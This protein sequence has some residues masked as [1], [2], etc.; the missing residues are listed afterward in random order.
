MPGTKA[1]KAVEVG[2][3]RLDRGA[4]LAL[5]MR[6]PIQPCRGE[7]G[8]LG[9]QDKRAQGQPP[10]SDVTRDCDANHQ[11]CKDFVFVTTVHE[12]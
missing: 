6:E 7:G 1:E 5:L 10:M 2:A 12:A 9:V 8:N 3:I 4:R 11:A